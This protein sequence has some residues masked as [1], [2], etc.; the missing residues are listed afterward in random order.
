MTS[1]QSLLV[2]SILLTASPF[3]TGDE[4]KHIIQPF[5]AEHCASCHGAEKQKGKLRLDTLPADFT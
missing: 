4:F 3:C 5:I 2:F 1:G